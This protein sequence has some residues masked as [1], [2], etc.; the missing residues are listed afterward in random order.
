MTMLKFENEQKFYKFQLLKNK[1]DH[2]RSFYETQGLDHSQSVQDHIRSCLLKHELDL[3]VHM[4]LQQIKLV[5][6]FE[7]N[8]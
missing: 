4:L 3:R 8:F 6:R 2:L 1:L 7:I 5:G